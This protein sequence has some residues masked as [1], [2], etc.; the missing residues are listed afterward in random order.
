MNIETVEAQSL[1]AASIT[2]SAA[3][4]IIEA[5]RTA[6]EKIGFEVAVAVTDAGGHLKAFE[7]TDGAPFLA[8]EIAVDKAWTAAAFRIATHVWNSHVGNPQIAPL[9]NW[10][11]LVAVGGGYPIVANGTVVG[12]LGVSGGSYEQD[13]KAAEAALNSLGFDLPS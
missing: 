12:G 10:P 13:Q 3:A 11:R 5:A 2:R 9:A 1:P 7:R 6:A 8:A 4:A